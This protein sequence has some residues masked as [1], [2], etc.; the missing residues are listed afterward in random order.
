MISKGVFHFCLNLALN[1]CFLRAFNNDVVL[2]QT[3]TGLLVHRRGSLAKRSKRGRG[4]RTL[5]RPPAVW[6]WT[7][8]RSASEFVFSSVKW[9]W[10]LCPRAWVR[11][12]RDDML[13]MPS[14]RSPH[15]GHGGALCHS[16]LPTSP[17]RT[18]P[19]FCAH[20][21]AGLETNGHVHFFPCIIYGTVGFDNY[22][23]FAASNL[24]EC[25]CP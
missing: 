24:V 1:I 20:N 17:L 5:P 7:V 12:K 6:T 19:L 10:C 18:P 13:Q 8:T 23:R 3:V 2:Q 16:F 15:L 14:T 9:G 21:S 25:F 22:N 11:I 4:V